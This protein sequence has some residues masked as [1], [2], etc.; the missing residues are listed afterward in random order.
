MNE[1]LS[2]FTAS[3][4]LHFRK[5]AQYF[6]LQNHHNWLRWL[7]DKKNL[8][9]KKDNID[10]LKMYRYVVWNHESLVNFKNPLF[11]IIPVTLLVTGKYFKFEIEQNSSLSHIFSSLNR[12]D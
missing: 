9:L 3:F 2:H 7:I 4:C 12:T 11:Y 5:I 8:N 1:K 10:K 6:N